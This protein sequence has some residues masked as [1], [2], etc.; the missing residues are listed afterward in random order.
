[1]LPPHRDDTSQADIPSP[2]E[3]GIS[4][5]RLA[6]VTAALQADVD[7]GRIPGAV[8]IVGRR[9][10]TAYRQ[11]IGFRDRGA[12]ARMNVD[13]IFRIA[14]MTK[15]ITIVAALL[16]AEQGRLLLADPVATYLPELANVRVGAETFGSGGGM[17]LCLEAAHRPMTVLD[18]MRH[19]AGFTYARFGSSLVKDTYTEAKVMDFD[20]TNAE[21]V[22]KLSELPLAYQP[23]TTWEYGMSTDVLG[24]VIER[25]A[26]VALDQFVAERITRPLGMPDTRFWIEQHE[27]DR[28]AQPHRGDQGSAAVPAL[29]HPV[30]RPNWIS[31]G[32][33]MVSTATDYA[34]FC[35][36]LLQ[37]GALDGTRLLAPHSVA[38]MT[39]QHLPPGICYAPHTATL[40]EALA[41][42][43]EMGHGFG[44]GVAVRLA[45]G[46]N[47]L[48]GSTG[49]YWW[50]G[51]TGT[52]F[53]VDPLEQMF[54]VLMLQAPEIRLQYRYLLRQLV[55]QALTG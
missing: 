46:G 34:R 19:T 3:V 49:D 21:L 53:W 41:P 23:G 45:G 11:A 26:G 18:L 40:F 25:V 5:A 24:C 39:S 14:S 13:T 43:P 16:L 31:G 32:G 4:S 20:Q 52:Y 28:L 36:M 35:Q 1:M 6:R 42:T 48:P 7:A 50:T 33:G 54:V 2:D 9:G 15:P 8:V 51:A 38:L 29:R 47:P 17:Q 30:G 22:G 44:L 37:G 10:A 55:Y 27:L 12:G